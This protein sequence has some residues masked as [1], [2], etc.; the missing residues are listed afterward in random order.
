M[1]LTP[2]QARKLAITRGVLLGSFAGAG[3]TFA[4]GVAL[5]FVHSS[6][7]V[8]AVTWGIFIEMAVSAAVLGAFARC[9]ACRARLGG[10]TGRL[11]PA[12]CGRCGVDLSDP[13]RP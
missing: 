4:L 12:R 10:E 7:A 6:P 1:T 9:P 3:A 11:L 13:A 2:E 8:R 5:F